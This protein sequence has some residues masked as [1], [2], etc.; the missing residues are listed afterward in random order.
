[1]RGEH[2]SNSV[3][4]VGTTPTFFGPS[5]GGWSILS[6]GDMFIFS[7]MREKY[8]FCCAASPRKA[9]DTGGGAGEWGNQGEGEE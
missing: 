4:H 3:K 1:M 7:E 5:D 2:S 9:S 8:G 6:P